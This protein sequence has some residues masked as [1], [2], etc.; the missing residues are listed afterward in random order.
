M[1]SLGL[2]PA[3]YGEKVGLIILKDPSSSESAVSSLSSQVEVR[4]AAWPTLLQAVVTDGVIRAW[5]QEETSASDGLLKTLHLGV[6]LSGIL[7]TSSFFSLVCLDVCTAPTPNAH[8][9]YFGC[10]IKSQ[11]TEM[12]S[13]EAC[14]PSLTSSSLQVSFLNYRKTDT[15]GLESENCLQLTTWS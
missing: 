11:T 1:A 4:G 15:L 3:L 14:G 13:W 12:Q 9:A 2:S 5:G 6:R 10:K 8:V 7:V